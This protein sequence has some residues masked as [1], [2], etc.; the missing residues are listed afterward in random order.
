MNNQL[1]GSQ[2]SHYCR[3]IT[4][5]THT[6]SLLNEQSTTGLAAVTFLQENN[7]WYTHTHSLL[8]EQST[9]GLAAVTFLQE[10]TPHTQCSQWTVSLTAHNRHI[11]AGEYLTHTAITVLLKNFNHRA[12]NS[13]ILAGEYISRTVFSMESPFCSSQQ[14][15]SCR[16][17]IPDTHSSHIPAGECTWHTWYK[18]FSVESQ[19]HSSQQTHSCRRK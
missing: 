13:Y 6:H 17:I 5:D 10:N 16:R 14:T 7:T 2:Q 18:V 12:N 8:N 11:L 4:L 1:Q 9:T 3:K 19:S 15:H